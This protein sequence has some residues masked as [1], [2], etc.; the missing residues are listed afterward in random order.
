MVTFAILMVSLNFGSVPA[1]NILIARYTPM[2]R[3]GLVFGLKFVLALG[4]ASMGVMLEGF[5]FD[6]SGEFTAVFRVLAGLALMGTCAIL[7]LPAERKVSA[8]VE[9]A[10]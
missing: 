9:A 8:L 10:E 3:R 2:H 1:E 4:I 5:L 7:M 6:I